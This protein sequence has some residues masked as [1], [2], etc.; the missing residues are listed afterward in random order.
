MNRYLRQ[1]AE[2][3]LG[4]RKEPPMIGTDARTRRNAGR[5]DPEKVAGLISRMRAA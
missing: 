4:Y 2:F 5:G 1:L 3:K